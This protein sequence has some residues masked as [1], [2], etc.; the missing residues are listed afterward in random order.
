MHQFMNQQEQFTE[1]LSKTINTCIQ[2]NEERMDHICA[3]E[4]ARNKKVYNSD[5]KYIDT[6]IDKQ[7]R[8]EYDMFIKNMKKD[9]LG[10]DTSKNLGFKIL[11]KTPKHA[12]L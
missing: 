10:G 3:I 9:I 12:H 7:G 6:V 2:V 5:I 11:E 8:N 1:S 4:S